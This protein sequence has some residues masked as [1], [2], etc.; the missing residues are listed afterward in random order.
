MD[1]RYSNEIYESDEKQHTHLYESEETH[2]HVCMSLMKHT[3]TRF[4]VCHCVYIQL[5][6]V[7]GANLQVHGVHFY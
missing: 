5:L 4:Q 7:I 1:V 3:H 6:A 2:T